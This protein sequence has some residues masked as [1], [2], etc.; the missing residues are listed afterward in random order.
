M[1]RA[2]GRRVKSRALVVAVVAGALSLGAMAH[3][4][5]EATQFPDI[6]FSDARFDI[7]VLVGAGV[8][9][10]TPVF[11]PDSTLTMPDLAAWAALADG[12]GEGGET[13]DVEALADAAREQGLVDSLEGEATYADLNRLLFDGRLTPENPGASPT[14]AEAASF[15]AAQLDEPAGIALLEQLGLRQG[16]VGDVS[17]VEHKETETGASAYFITVADT[18]LPFYAHG[19][20]ANGPTDLLQWEGR[21]VR[22]SFI[23]E[24]G[25]HELWA[26]LEAEPS[27]DRGAGEGE[28]HHDDDDHHHE[29]G[30]DTGTDRTL[31]YGL[32]AAVPVLGALLFFKRKRSR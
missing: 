7:V 30:A 19:R 22:R 26:Y 17:K 10:E 24:R 1:S 25:G 29:A 28:A 14:K 21:S 8:I 23:R 3:V 31:M 5:N 2:R 9:P 4:K 6:E 15:I 27:E 32:I 11:E 16:P 20:V 12:L 18:T 13:P